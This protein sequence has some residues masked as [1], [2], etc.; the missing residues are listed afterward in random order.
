MKMKTAFKVVTWIIS[1]GLALAVGTLCALL[2]MNCIPSPGTPFDAILLLM[3]S[4]GFA[5]VA[6]GI[7]WLLYR[8][9]KALL[10]RPR[11]A[12]GSH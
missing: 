5:A 12:G 8:V 10:L 11:A 3:V 1:I 9:A 7:V 2:V 6:F 4:V